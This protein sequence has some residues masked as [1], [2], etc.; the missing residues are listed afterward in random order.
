MHSIGKNDV[1][2]Y[3]RAS[4]YYE[5]AFQASDNAHSDEQQIDVPCDCLQLSPAVV[6]ESDLHALLKTVRFWLVP[7]HIESNWELFAFVV[8]NA[9]C[10][11]RMIPEFGTELPFLVALRNTM[12]PTA[13]RTMMANAATLGNIHV[14]KYLHSSG[15]SWD[16]GVDQPKFTNLAA[17]N[18]RCDCLGYALDNGCGM[19]GDEC[20]MAIKGDH[21]DCLKCAHDV[22]EQAIES[23]AINCVKY[24][25][26]SAAL[27]VQC[28]ASCCE[29]AALH[30]HINILEYLICVGCVVVTVNKAICAAVHDKSECLQLLCEK[31]CPV[32]DETLHA[33]VHYGSIAC[34]QYLHAYGRLPLASTNSAATTCNE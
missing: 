34:V 20:S 6:T 10:L 29:L 28:R 8:S 5:N 4:P 23:G 21:V 30:G 18:G 13:P 27:E 31:G 32:D 9:E 12:R 24:I 19:D 3:L 26:S 15:H 7:E 25:A 22:C 33:A 2:Q 1:P 14:V 11:D 16:T 17:E